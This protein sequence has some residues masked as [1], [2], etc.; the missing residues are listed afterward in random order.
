M[1]SIIIVSERRVKKMKFKDCLNSYENDNGL[2]KL[3]YHGAVIKLCNNELLIK[4]NSERKLIV[5]DKNNKLIESDDDIFSNCFSMQNFLYNEDDF[6]VNKFHKILENTNYKHIM[7]F[8]RYNNKVYDSMYHEFLKYVR[9]YC[10]T[11]DYQ[12]INDW[13]KL[14]ANPFKKEKNNL[15]LKKYHPELFD[16]I[17]STWKTINILP[18][19]CDN[20]QYIYDI[21][22]FIVGDDINNYL[23]LNKDTNKNFKNIGDLKICMHCYN[24]KKLEFF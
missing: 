4:K 8:A 23:E 17:L 2:Y 24:K 7:S 15:F 19:Q 5:T 11:Y 9:L 3:L 20:C 18:F 16:F 1:L 21:Q 6:L 12:V 22:E 14:I 10:S 13:Y